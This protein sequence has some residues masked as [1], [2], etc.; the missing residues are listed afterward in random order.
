MFSI[1]FEINQNHRKYCP[2]N[3]HLTLDK[4][5]SILTF[6]IVHEFHKVTALCTKLCNKF[7]VDVLQLQHK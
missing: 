1:Q 2:T 6:Q 7:L 4:F 3:A 5:L